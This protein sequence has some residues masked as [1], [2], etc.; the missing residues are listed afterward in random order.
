MSEYE[1]H[2][3]NTGEDRLPCAENTL[4][5][6]RCG[7][8]DKL[9]APL[10]AGCSSCATD[11]LEWVSSSGLGYIISWRVVERA[12]ISIKGESGQLTIAIVELDDGPWLYTAIEG[13]VPLL[14]SRPVRVRFVRRPGKDGF[15]VFAPDA[16]AGR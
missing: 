8:C 11:E 13:Q 5:I 12:S 7:D 1:R 9:F 6:Q 2:S 4:M 14:P 10:A 16:D 15:P 3:A